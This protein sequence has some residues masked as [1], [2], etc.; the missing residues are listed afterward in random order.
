MADSQDKP[1][2]TPDQVADTLR[3]LGVR[4]GDAIFVHSSLSSLGH[5][6]GGADGLIDG[7]L[8]AVGPGG[9]LA[10][11]T[12]SF[13][14][15]GMS[16][17]G[18]PYDPA[19][20][21]SRIGKVPDLFRRRP[22]AV[23]S[24]HPTHSVAVMGPAAAAMAAGHDPRGDTFAITGPH[25]HCVRANAK[26]VFIGVGQRPNTTCHVAEDW[27][28]LPFMTDSEGLLAVPGGAEVIT[29]RKRPAGH[30]NYT[31]K[32]VGPCVGD[33]FV[34]NGQLVET[35]L[36][37]TQFVMIHA[38]DVI[39][40]VCRFEI[41]QPACVLCHDRSCGF[42]ELGRTLCI[43]QRD[44]ICRRAGELLARGELTDPSAEP[45]MPE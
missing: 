26:I 10:M 7:L 43:R 13:G 14:Y 30:R 2:V 22:G 42:C 41:E 37:D 24:G 5:M 6:D 18:I 9:H 20:T 29:L 12:H 11:P 34:A 16:R 44:A 21:P 32:A 31:G 4:A 15:H 8:A 38:R 1:T 27:L 17:P 39:G 28:D 33:R 35:R 45:I 25:G 19:T 36:N 3:R 23:R 40:E